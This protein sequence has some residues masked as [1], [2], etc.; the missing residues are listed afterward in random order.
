[1]RLDVAQ[2]RFNECVILIKSAFTHAGSV[3]RVFPADTIDM[4]EGA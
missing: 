2:M 3:I 1:V 4:R